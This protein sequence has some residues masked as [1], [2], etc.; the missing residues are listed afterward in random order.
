MSNPTIFRTSKTPNRPPQTQIRTT[1]EQEED[2]NYVEQQEMIQE[3]I[4]REANYQETTEC[5]P[6]L[7]DYNPYK[8]EE[9]MK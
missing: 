6:Y 9:E 3:E 1:E 2:E 4:K 5:Q 8:E 7:E